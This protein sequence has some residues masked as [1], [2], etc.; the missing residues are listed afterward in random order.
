[1][2]SHLKQIGEIGGKSD[3]KGQNMAPRIEIVH[4]EPLVTRVPPDIFEPVHVDQ[5]AVQGNPIARPQL[6]VRQIDGQHRVV[7]LDVR[8]EEQKRRTVQPQFELRQKP[9]VIEVNA[10][11]IAG[12]GDNVAAR[13]KQRE[14]IAGFEGSWTALLERDVRFDIEWRGLVLAGLRGG[15]RRAA[16][17]AGVGQA[18]SRAG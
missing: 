2:S 1:M 6:G 18:A 5:F 13:V 15:G 7:F 9:G 8:A 3:P 16:G 12:S 11:G 4:E 10:V 14:G 17:F